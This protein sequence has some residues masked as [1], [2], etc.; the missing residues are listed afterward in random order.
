M[1]NSTRQLKVIRALFYTFFWV[2][3]RRMN[4]MCRRFGAL[5][6][7]FTG[8]MN[9]PLVKTQQTD[10]SETSARKIHTPGN[11]PNERIQHSHQ[12]ESL[13]SI[14]CIFLFC[15]KF[16]TD[17]N[18]IRYMRCP[19]PSRSFYECCGNCSSDSCTVESS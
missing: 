8:G 1:N 5:C 10:R 3:P 13:K 19:K 17:L 6:S 4:F 14:N 7:I 9:T 11:R 2:I 16:S 18:Q 15:A 12:V